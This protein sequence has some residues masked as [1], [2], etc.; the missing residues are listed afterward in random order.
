MNL[1]MKIVFGRYDTSAWDKFSLPVERREKFQDVAEKRAFE[2]YTNH[3]LG[4]VT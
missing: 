1:Q 2:T 4:W 3:L